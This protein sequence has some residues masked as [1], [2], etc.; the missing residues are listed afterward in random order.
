MAKASR[1][2]EIANQVFIG[3][4][5]KRE[6]AKYERIIKRLGRKYS[7]SFVIVGRRDGQDAEEL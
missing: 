2:K 1:E 7:L 5:W 4:P 3:C 6:R